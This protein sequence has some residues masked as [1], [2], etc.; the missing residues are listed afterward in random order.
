MFALRPANQRGHTQTGWL[1][2]YHTFSFGDYYDPEF[3]GFSDLRVINDDIVA[4]EQGFGAHPHRDMEIVSIVLSGEL[5]HKDS[6]GNGSVIRPGEIQKMSAGSG[7]YHSEFNPSAT[8]P[9]HFLQIW[10]LPNMRA[11][12][13][14]YQ[15]KQ[16]S[17]QIMT[18]QLKLIVSPDG[19]EESLIISQD[20]EIYQTLLNRDKTVSFDINDRRKAWIQI[21][22]GSVMVNDQPMVAGDGLAVADENTPV[23]IRGVDEQSNIIVFNLRK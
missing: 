19:R 6:L 20:A 2:S 8:D 21:A 5:E 4:P 15:Q 1:D 7:I 22:G 23:Q 13:P 16:F 18:D 14:S 10:I 12:K 9:V 3:M 17:P 11:L